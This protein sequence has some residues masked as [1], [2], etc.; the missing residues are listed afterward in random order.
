VFAAAENR[1]GVLEPA[2]ISRGLD[3]LETTPAGRMLGVPPPLLENAAAKAGAQGAEGVTAV[4]LSIKLRNIV[5][6]GPKN[7]RAAGTGVHA[8]LEE[9]GGP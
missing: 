9:N 1:T 5:E 2:A 6:A 4:H 7:R 3:G 8:A